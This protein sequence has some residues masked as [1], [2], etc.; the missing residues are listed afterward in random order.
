MT[1]VMAVG[2]ADPGAWPLLT[3]CKQ[4]IAARCA[5]ARLPQT[6]AQA[7][8]ETGIGDGSRRLKNAAFPIRS[9]NLRAFAT[10]RARRGARSRGAQPR[11]RARRSC[12]V[13]PRE[14]RPFQGFSL[15]HKG[16]AA[17]PRH[18][19]IALRAIATTRFSR[20]PQAFI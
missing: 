11:P 3:Q 20:A 4:C 5:D 2:R 9:K 15:R 7:G 8:F 13:H 1:F 6:C 19:R 16:S 17:R 18:A 10:T 12:A 14:N